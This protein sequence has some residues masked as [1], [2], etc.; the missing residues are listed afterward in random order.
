MPPNTI[1]AAVARRFVLGR[2]GLWPGRRFHG[3]RGLREALHVVEHLQLD[4]LNITARSQDI[5]LH[6]RVHDFEPVQ[7]QQLAYD[8]LEF[9]DWGAWLALRPI[10]YLPYYRTLMAQVPTETRYRDWVAAHPG[11]LNEMREVVR[12]E[13]PVSNRDFQAASRRRVTHYRGRKDSSVA[14]YHLWRSGELMIHNS[15]RG[16]RV[17]TS[18]P[19]HR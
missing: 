2:Q 8:K 5:M 10:D 11:V 13:G 12:A 9:F 7:W 16:W 1:P 4:P 3:S 18:R 19:A 15:W 17:S 6:A 14:L